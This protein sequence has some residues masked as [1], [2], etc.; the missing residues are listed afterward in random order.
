MECPACRTVNL[1]PI[2]LEQNLPA[3]GCQTCHGAL[4]SLLYYRDWAERTGN[5]LDLSADADQ[6][7]LHYVAADDSHK[8][9]ACPKCKHLMRK[10][11]VSEQSRH[12]LDLCSAC[13]EVWLDGGEWQWLKTLHLHTDLVSVLSETWQSRVKL[14]VLEQKHR[15]RFARV[16]GE[17]TMVKAEEVRR[18]LKD[19]IYRQEILYYLSR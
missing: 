8:A 1:A 14:E 6:A 11:L 2:K 12:R 10:F 9:L 18:W 7:E 3:Y 4:V 15:D 17:D 5:Q 16:V 19:H 13:D